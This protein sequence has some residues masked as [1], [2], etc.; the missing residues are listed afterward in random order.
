MYLRMLLPVPTLKH[1]LAKQDPAAAHL[2]FVTIPALNAE[3]C[4]WNVEWIAPSMT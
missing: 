4:H 1:H 3:G 2:I